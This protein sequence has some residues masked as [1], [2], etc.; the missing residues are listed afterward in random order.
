VR[1]RLDNRN[2]RQ[3]VMPYYVCSLPN[4]GEPGVPHECIADDPRIIEAFAQREDRPGRGVYDCVSLLKPGARR[5][6]LDTVATRDALHV[7]IDAK[8]I[9]EDLQA[10]DAR[11]AGLL[12]PPSEVRNSGHGRHVVYNLKEPISSD[13]DMARAASVLKQLTAHLCGDPAVAHHAALLRRPGTHNSK[14]S[15]WTVCENVMLTGATYDLGDIEDWLGDVGGHALFSRRNA[16]NGHDPA[17]GADFAE[18][19]PPI[20]VEA[21]LAAMKFQGD[22]TSSIH[23]TQLSVTASLLRS[24][25]A[26]LEATRIV[27][28]ATRAAAANDPKWDWRREEL[29]ILRMGSDFIAK[30]PE[31]T[32][33]LPDKWRARFKEAL[34]LGRRADIGY[35]NS[36]FYVRGWKIGA[37]AAANPTA[38]GQDEPHKS[39]PG[40]NYYN[41]TE[42]K[43]QRWCVKQLLPESGVGIVSGQW[44]SFK[45]T[46]ALDLSVSVMTSEPFA[47]QYRIKRP[48]GVLYF[49]TEGAGTLQARLAA[50]ARH[51]GA[52]KELPFAWRADCPMLTD[53]GAGDAM[54]KMVDDAAAHFEHA[55]GVPITVI[56]VDTYITAAGLNSSGD[57]NDAAATQK[58]FSTLRFVAARSK[59]FV[60]TID[61]LGKVVEAGTRGSSGKEGNA[62]TV[63]ATLAEREITGS[64][65]NGR[66]AIRKQRDGIS[67]FAVPFVP[68]VVELGLD[69]DGDPVTAIILRWSKQQRQ[70]QAKKPKSKDAELL[71]HVLAE[72]VAK[73]GF[74]FQPD[75]GGPAVQACHGSV[76]RAA[77]YERRHAEGTAKQKLD[78]HRVA[79][80]RAMEIATAA[81]LV[82]MRDWNGEEVIWPR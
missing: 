47:G 48:G 56:W 19:R 40:W 35:N 55:Y 24:G 8:D 68:E 70:E 3:S 22:G 73:Q 58:A 64:I 34:A 16:G 46:A 77:F 81:A 42:A 10:V 5:R 45:T 25:V 36:G 13:A 6:S 15:E 57:D 41:N 50:I 43:P 63:L 11:L 1:T 7:D 65:S 37:T 51:R 49:A 66:M 32:I 54:V 61:H 53:R 23:Q 4:P 29:K 78:K 33:L 72:V 2:A 28:E 44:G 38:G 71:C 31:L 62:D 79:F 75:P 30:H 21:R 74:A 27:L 12:L 39:K 17:A 67:G 20:D 76:L 52:P 18:H 69:E 14:N 60:V 26:L 9:V 82:A 80:K 59:A